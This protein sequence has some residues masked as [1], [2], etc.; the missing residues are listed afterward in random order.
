MKSITQIH[1]NR[2]AECLLSCGELFEL[3]SR[4]DSETDREMLS[5]A[6]QTSGGVV[7]LILKEYNLAPEAGAKIYNEIMS[8]AENSN[9]EVYKR[10]SDIQK[11]EILVIN[12]KEFI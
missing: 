2:I 10:M 12:S 3:K 11:S 6:I 4:T 1:K 7:K 8:T 9:R 5:R